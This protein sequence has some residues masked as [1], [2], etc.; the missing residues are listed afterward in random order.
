MFAGGRGAKGLF[1]VERTTKGAPPVRKE[2]SCG[3]TWGGAAT[4]QTYFVWG[5]GRWIVGGY[6]QEGGA[7][8]GRG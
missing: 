4:K 6:I 3:P 1:D 5:D 7:R 8:A 2:K